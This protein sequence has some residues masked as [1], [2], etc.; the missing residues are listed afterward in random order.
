MET[1]NPQERVL[2]YDRHLRV[3]VYYEIEEN[4]DVSKITG[5]GPS[6][7]DARDDYEYQYCYFRDLHKNHLGALTNA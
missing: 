2:Y 7:K 3:W 5:Y 6:V 1:R 4:G